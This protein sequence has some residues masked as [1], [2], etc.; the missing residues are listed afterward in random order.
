MKK[1]PSHK[2]KNK[3]SKGTTQEAQ[4]KPPT[5][6]DRVMKGWVS[7]DE[8]TKAS[9]SNIA[10]ES[11]GSQDISVSV[12]CW[13]VLADSYCSRR[14][15]RHLPLVYQN[16]VFDRHQRQH[17]VRQILRQMATGGL[18]PDLLA[19]QEVDP[20]LEIPSCLEECGYQGHH[21]PTDPSGRNGRVD[22]CALYYRID[23]WKSVAV[24]S[25]R[26]DDIATLCSRNQGGAF[27]PS[28]RASLE[29]IETSFLRKNVALLVRLQ[30]LETGQEIVI[31]V[32]HLFWNPLYQ[33][34]KLCQA[35]YVAIKTHSFAKGTPVLFVGDTNSQPKSAVHD[36][37]WR[38]VVNAKQVAPWYN[39]DPFRYENEKDLV[40]PLEKLSLAETASDNP[41]E[42][43]QVRYLLDFTLNRLC[44][45]L[46]ILGIDAG[47][48]TEEE[49]RMRTKDGNL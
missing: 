48:E 11:S 33:E 4:E 22:S 14:S 36:Y 32:M 6:V 20:P 5:W 10:E 42:L 9:P 28:T 23:T 41:S 49:E 18:R 7:V 31:A 26:L 27:N 35:H 24:E 15:H 39:R 45:W 8:E 25:I 44:R 29:G 1:K 2:P 46:R 47:L 34:V 43:P 16:H 37:F 40:Q 30:H 13:N 19:L 17:H 12:V 3:K 38:G 21:T